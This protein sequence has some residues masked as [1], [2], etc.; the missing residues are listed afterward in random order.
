MSHIP[1]N[2]PLRPLYR[3]LAAIVGGFVLVF[4]VVGFIATAGEPFLSRSEAAALGLRTNLAFSIASVVAGAVILLALL[5]GR[6]VDYFVNVWGGLAFLTVGMAA[7]TLLHT[8]LNVFNF[9]VATVIVS[10]V[11]GL[12][13]FAAGLYGRSGSTAAALAE[14]AMRHGGH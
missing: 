3:A 10:F 12:V 9:S 5:V 1:I 2:H 14:E 8:D 11:I 6:N 7:L 13:L 4:G